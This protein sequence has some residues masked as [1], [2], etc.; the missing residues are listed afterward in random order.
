MSLLII[1]LV[2]LQLALDLALLF[3]VFTFIGNL[4]AITEV[5]NDLI[6]SIQNR[7]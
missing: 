3:M 7:E 1:I 2:V 6:D 4:N 5:V